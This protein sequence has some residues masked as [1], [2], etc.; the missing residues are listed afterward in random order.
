MLS[1]ILSQSAERDV[2]E[3]WCS[4]DRMSSSIDNELN[5]IRLRGRKI[6]KERVEGV[7]SRT[8]ERGS[9]S[10]ISVVIEK[11]PNSPKYRE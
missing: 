11:P 8:N 3:F 2:R 10:N 5:T 9:N 1:L 4:G 6:K 7:K